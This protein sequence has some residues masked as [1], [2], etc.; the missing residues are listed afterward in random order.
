LSSTDLYR[1]I[2]IL[3]VLQQEEFEVYQAIQ[4]CLLYLSNTVRPDIAFATNQLA[5]FM[6][7]PNSNHLIAIKQVLRYLKG[8]ID[9][10]IT[11]SCQVSDQCQMLAY[12]DAQW[13]GDRLNTRSISGLSIQMN[14]GSIS[15]YSRRQRTTA[16]SSCEAEY[17]GL[18][19]CCRV[20]CFLLSLLPDLGAPQ[21]LPCRVFEDNTS[22]IHI[23]NNPVCG[24]RT[25]HINQRYH[26][27]REKIQ[28]H[29]VIVIYCPTENMVADIF[30]KAL[31]KIKF[32]QFRA[33]LMGSDRRYLWLFSLASIEMLCFI[34]YGL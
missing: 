9:L 10:G 24:Q 31:D 7:K 21:R 2:E 15:W 22:T 27:V 32:H 20:L 16:L 34:C 13:G 23:A 19:D 8:T 6:S 26:F 5:Q 18:S 11:Y 17:I 28:E 3:P 33:M 25:R 1:D 30:T 4:G 14:G 12:S 29:Q